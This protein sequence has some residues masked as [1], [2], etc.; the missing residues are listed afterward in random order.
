[1]RSKIKYLIKKSIIFEMLMQQNWF[2]N[3]RYSGLLESAETFIETHN[4][5]INN[6]PENIKRQ[7]V[8]AKVRHNVAF[9]EFFQ[10]QFDGKS[11]KYK[12]TFI[13]DTE[14]KLKYTD[15]LN[16]N[17]RLFRDKYQAYQF[18]KPY[19]K[20]EIC[21]F[22][23]ENDLKTVMAFLERH[24]RFIVKPLDS[25]RGRG[26]KIY[27]TDKMSC[28]E[29]IDLIKNDYKNSAVILEELIRQDNSLS[30][31]HPQSVNTVR[32]VTFHLG[33]HIEC[34]YP[35]L[36]MGVGDS[37]VDNGGAGGIFAAIDLSTG[38]LL[39][40]VDELGREYKTHPDTGIVF[41]DFSVPKWQKA[42]E[43]S[44]ELASKTLEN[45]YCSWDLALANNEWVLVEANG[46]G[47]L[48]WQIAA[49]IGLRS[50]LSILTKKIKKSM[51]S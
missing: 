37:I 11:E 28:Q 29:I 49:N 1:M 17:L 18:F 7:M 48:L 40:C 3:K 14:R 34:R 44:V 6:D 24:K 8:D 30:V 2:L 50:D 41:A 33:D 25:S 39:R 35:V 10:F 20:R 4:I 13:G 12:R 15:Q 5:S 22:E 16:N 26:I 23:E 21:R 43:L 38:K 47:H 36:R 9:D 31:L 27:E 32:T 19:Y 51:K 42:K 46:S 45:R